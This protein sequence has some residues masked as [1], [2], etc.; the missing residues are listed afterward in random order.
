MCRKIIFSVLLAYCIVLAAFNVPTANAQAAA[1]K[2]TPVR[3]QGGLT[4]N[5]KGSESIFS[6]CVGSEFA[7]R[8]K[9][10]L[11]PFLP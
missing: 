3:L 7:G 8:Q 1:A 11:T 6:S 10:I 2:A 4:L 5:R 9:S